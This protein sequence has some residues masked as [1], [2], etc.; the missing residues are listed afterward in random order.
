MTTGCGTSCLKYK[1]YSTFK[2]QEHF[3]G[4]YAMFSDKKLLTFDGFS[5]FIFSIK[6]A[7]LLG[8]L[9]PEDEGSIFHIIYI[10]V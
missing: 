1:I 4:C 2:T 6:Q 8:L 9:D 5:P 10:Y 7:S 3:L